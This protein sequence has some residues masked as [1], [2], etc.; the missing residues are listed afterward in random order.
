M[1]GT[2]RLKESSSCRSCWAHSHHVSVRRYT[3][4]GR[5]WPPP[6]PGYRRSQ[7]KWMGAPQAAPSKPLP[8][9]PRSPPAPRLGWSQARTPR[10]HCGGAAAIACAPVRR[11]RVRGEHGPQVARHHGVREVVLRDM[12]VQLRRGGRHV[13]KV[14]HD[15]E[16]VHVHGRVQRS[17]CSGPSGP[18]AAGEHR[19]R[20]GG[21]GV[22][23]HMPRVRTTEVRGCGRAGRPGAGCTGPA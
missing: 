22:R 16:G 7:A 1:V 12:A 3:L 15:A 4:R 11:R 18:A 19:T 21:T 2:T 14:H 10:R 20:R 5:A 13:Q 17:A 8:A 9:G 23:E 6:C